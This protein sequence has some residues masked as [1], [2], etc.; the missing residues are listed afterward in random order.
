MGEDRSSLPRPPSYSQGMPSHLKHHTEYYT[1]RGDLI[2]Q[3]KDTLFKVSAYPFW[4]QSKFFD[5]AASE[6]GTTVD[7]LESEKERQPRNEEG[8]VWKLKNVEVHEFERL[9]WEVE[10]VRGTDDRAASVDDWV[11]ILKLSDRWGFDGI[12]LKAAKKLLQL[13]MNPVAKIQLVH[14]HKIR[15]EWALDALMKLTLQA[16]SPDIKDTAVLQLAITTHLA[17]AREKVSYMFPWN[18]R[19]PGPV[20][21]IICDVFKLDSNFSMPANWKDLKVGE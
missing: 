15:L 21:E 5:R 12:A 11:A 20:R 4:T 16:E 3:V 10:P 17:R 6:N 18:R 9:M 13:D 19:R 14:Q 7:K 8:H 2:I 1:E